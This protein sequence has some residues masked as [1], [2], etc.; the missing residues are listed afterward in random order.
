MVALNTLVQAADELLDVG[1]FK[2]Y[3]PNGLQLEGKPGCNALCLV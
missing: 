1:R 2:D 3:A